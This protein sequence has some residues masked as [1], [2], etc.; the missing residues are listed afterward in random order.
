MMTGLLGIAHLLGTADHRRHRPAVHGIGQ[1]GTD[2]A[3]RRA[4]RY[5][6]RSRQRPSRRAAAIMAA[7]GRPGTLS[8]HGRRGSMIAGQDPAK[9]RLP[10]KS[11]RRLCR[12]HVGR[13]HEDHSRSD[14]AR[15]RDGLG[16][17]YRAAAGAEIRQLHRGLSAAPGRR[18]SGGHG[19]RQRADHG[20]GEG[21]RRRDGAAGGGHVPRVHG[22]AT[23]CRNAAGDGAG[24]T[25]VDVAQ[26]TRRAA[27]ISS[28][29]MAASST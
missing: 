23:R 14:R 28:A 2:R 10:G 8:G 12:E 29:A 1:G 25:V 13:A 17:G 19:P 21:E 3:G 7:G 6:L 22:P 11:V 27:T 20:G 16:A 5:R 26:R 18:R 9:G 24:V 4:G 15:R